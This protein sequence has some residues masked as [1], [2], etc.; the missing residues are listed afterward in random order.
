[1]ENTYLDTLDIFNQVVRNYS[2]R[3]EIMITEGNVE[4]E[5]RNIMIASLIGSI[6]SSTDRQLL[7]TAVKVNEIWE[8]Y[9]SNDRHYRSFIL[10]V[11]S[12]FITRI[13]REQFESFA[14]D[15]AFAFSIAPQGHER[16]PFT[17]SEA[18]VY[19]ISEKIFIHNPWFMSFMLLGIYQNERES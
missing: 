10:D 18:S 4:G 14:K 5:T 17:A 12:E 2:F 15:V 3:S 6:V 13:G 8:Q 11:T 1:M 19:C 16:T 9:F 7:S